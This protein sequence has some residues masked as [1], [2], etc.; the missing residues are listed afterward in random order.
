MSSLE[1]DVLDI[2]IEITSILLGISE[3]QTQISDLQSRT[4][5]LEDRINALNSTDKMTIRVSFLSFTIWYGIPPPLPADYLFDVG[6]YIL[7]ENGQRR[8]PSISSARSG[9]SRFIKPT[10]VELVI[11]NGTEYNGAPL[12]I[13]HG[14]EVHVY[15]V[16]YF[17]LDDAAID[18]NP[19]PAWGPQPILRSNESG[20]QLFIAYSI[21]TVKVGSVDG[22]DDG[23]L[24]F[25][26]AYLQYRIE[27]FYG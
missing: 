7:D 14:D 24:D 8:Y 2:G 3:M 17:H 27:T 9:H 23:Y 18:I 6:V 19:D 15:V 10:F 13:H 21:G 11:R 5:E 22:R 1:K 25:S 16:A 12:S 4:V 26:D 20:S